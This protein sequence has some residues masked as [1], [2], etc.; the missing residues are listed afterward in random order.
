L[1]SECCSLKANNPSDIGLDEVN[2][3]KLLFLINIKITEITYLLQK[4]DKNARF[5][6]QK[7]QNF[8]GPTPDPHNGGAK[9][10]FTFLRWL[11]GPKG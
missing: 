10:A 7:V 8:S 5:G 1:K 9:P 11:R 3:N 2:D 4:V 6:M